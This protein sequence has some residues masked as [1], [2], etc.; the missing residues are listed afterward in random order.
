MLSKVFMKLKQALVCRG[1]EFGFGVS[2]LRVS[3]W[4]FGVMILGFWVSHLGL[5]FSLFGVSGAGIRD[6]GFRGL[7]FR[8]RFSRFGVSGAGFRV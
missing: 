7:G 8:F 1:F 4:R 2:R 6:S 3:S 5:G